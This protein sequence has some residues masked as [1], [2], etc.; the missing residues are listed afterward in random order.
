VDEA[1]AIL[2][3]LERRARERYVSPVPFLILHLGLAD[4]EAAFAAIERAHAER[5][6]WMAYLRVDPMLDPLRGDPRFAE[7]LRRMRL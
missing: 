5:R 2:A 3:Q 7:W 6:G 1:R 4:T